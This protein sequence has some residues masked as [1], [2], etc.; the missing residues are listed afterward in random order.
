MPMG[1]A[2]A[3]ANTKKELYAVFLLTMKTIN[4]YKL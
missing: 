2:I 1:E 4:L 3:G